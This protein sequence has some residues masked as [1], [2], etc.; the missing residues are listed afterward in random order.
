MDIMHIYNA[1]SRFT[2]MI[3]NI[4]IVGSMIGL[5]ALGRAI[6]KAYMPEEANHEP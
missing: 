1:M 5:V 2:E 3:G 6:F 4:L